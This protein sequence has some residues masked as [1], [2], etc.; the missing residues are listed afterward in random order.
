MVNSKVRVSK[1]TQDFYCQMYPE[2]SCRRVKKVLR[3]VKS[4]VG[5]LDAITVDWFMRPERARHMEALSRI[6]GGKR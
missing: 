1:E 2:V 5:R 6:F 4:Q 3:K